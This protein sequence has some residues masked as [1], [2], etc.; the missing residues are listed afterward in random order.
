MDIA[1]S[2]FAACTPAYPRMLGNAIIIREMNGGNDFLQHVLEMLAPL[3]TVRARRMFGGYGL[4]CGAGG[5][6]RR[7][8][9]NAQHAALAWRRQAQTRAL[10][11]ASR[12]AGRA[13]SC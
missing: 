8:S 5:K 6:A 1:L 7:R 11:L 2:P 3:R 13:N 12:V 10:T 9:T 4:Y